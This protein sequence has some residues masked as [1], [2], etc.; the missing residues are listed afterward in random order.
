MSIASVL[1]L[2]NM[3]LLLTMSIVGLYLLGAMGMWRLATV[4]PVNRA[5][6]AAMVVYV[7]T[8]LVPGLLSTGDWSTLGALIDDDVHDLLDIRGTPEECAARLTEE[9]GDLA[10]R[11][12]LTA[13]T[14]SDAALAAMVAALPASDTATR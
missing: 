10:D 4:F 1:A 5:R 7:G 8:P 14:A 3:G 13:S 6:I 12:S 11:V 2:F 9:Y